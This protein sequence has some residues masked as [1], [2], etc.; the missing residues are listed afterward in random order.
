MDKL[1]T[2][3]SAHAP[4]QTTNEYIETVL[5]GRPSSPPTTEPTGLC[6][7]L[8]NKRCSIYRARPFSCRCFV[9]TTPCHSGGAATVPEHHLYGTMAV[10]QII[11]HLCQ[12]EQWG[13]MHDV[14]LSLAVSPPYNRRLST[15]VGKEQT[16]KTGRHLLTAQPLPGFVIPETEEA[17]IAPL[18]HA[19]FTKKIGDKTIEQI[20]NGT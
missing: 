4:T 15:S 17:K 12:F 18:L 11:E 13:T 14:L 6:L 10:M 2:A 7:F 9:S 20:L 16:K 19:I 1:S 8:E 5:Q 3:T